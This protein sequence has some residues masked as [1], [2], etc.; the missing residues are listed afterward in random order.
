MSE[1]RFDHPWGCACGLGRRRVGGI[2][3][4]LSTVDHRLD[5]AGAG[6]AESQSDSQ[7]EIANGRPCRQARSQGTL[8][9]RLLECSPLL[10]RAD[11]VRSTDVF[12]LLAYSVSSPSPPISVSFPPR[13]LSA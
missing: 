7:T 6:K 11:A 3:D 12:L 2:A 13:P 10:P 4:L 8:K 5:S 1:E 9:C